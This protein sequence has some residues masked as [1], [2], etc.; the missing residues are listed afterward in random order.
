MCNLSVG[1]CVRHN[2]Q[3][4]IPMLVVCLEASKRHSR[5]DRH[6]HCGHVECLKQD[7]LGF[8]ETFVSKTGTMCSTSSQV[9]I[10]KPIVRLEASRDM[11]SLIATFLASTLN[12]TTMNCVVRLVFA[13][14][15]AAPEMSGLHGQHV[16]RIPQ[17]VYA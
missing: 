15:F 11:T 2:V 17:D 1:N 14:S 12:L 9:F 5:P 8:E 3:V 13:N 4:S 6:E 10:T 7:V 16:E